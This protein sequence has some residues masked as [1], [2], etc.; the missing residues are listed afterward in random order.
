MYLLWPEDVKQD[1]IL[2]FLGDVAAPYLVKAERNIEFF[3]TKM[4]HVTYFARSIH[5]VA[6]KIRK[7]FPKQSKCI[8]IKCKKY[9]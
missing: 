4:E 7:C 2:L 6:E 8:N 5:R 1:N 3:Y 9:I